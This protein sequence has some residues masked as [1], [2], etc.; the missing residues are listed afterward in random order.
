[1]KH[2]MTN[3]HRRLLGV[4]IAMAQAD[5]VL[6]SREQELLA[7]ICN[8]LGLSDEARAEVEQ[9][10]E[11]PPTPE[12]IA[13]WAV[14]EQDRLGIYAAAFQMARAD[15]HLAQEEQA[16]LDRLAAVLSLSS[17]EVERAT[18]MGGRP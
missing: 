2:D 18:R 10:I 12:Q 11:T 17:A 7:H 16:L 8:E 14:T 5:G 1:M 3:D 4:A 9:M 6:D 15:G 13:T